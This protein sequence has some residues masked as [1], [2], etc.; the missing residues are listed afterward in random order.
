MEPPG[1]LVG[2]QMLPA[3]LDDLIFIGSGAGFQYDI[4]MG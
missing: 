2:S 4:G 1:H 3:K